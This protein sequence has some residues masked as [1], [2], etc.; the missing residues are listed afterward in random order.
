MSESEQAACDGSLS[1][2]ATATVATASLVVLVVVYRAKA[3][4][5]CVA[6]SVSVANIDEGSIASWGSMREQEASD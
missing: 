3:F 1:I 6:A 5:S 4:D 2:A